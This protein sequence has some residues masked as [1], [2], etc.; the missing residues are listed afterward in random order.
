MPRKG[1]NIYKRKDGRWEGRFVKL[2]ENGRTRFGY[3]Y[4]R[5][6]GEA[7]EKLSTA[8]L[9]WQSSAERLSYVQGTMDSLCRQWLEDSK[10]FL[11]E[12]TVAKYSDYL[13]WY[14][15]PRFSGRDIGHIT[16]NDLSDFCAELMR[17]GGESGQ[18]LSPKTVSEVL[19]VMKQLRNFA[20]SKGCS[21]G[22]TAQTVVIRGKAKPIRVF[23]QPEYERLHA[24][25]LQNPSWEAWGVLLCLYTGIR[26]GELCALK[27]GDF[28]R[29]TAQLRIERTL[30]RINDYS[31][32]EA[33]T[34]IVITPPK[35]ESSI[36]TI[37]LPERIRWLTGFSLP[38]NTVFLTNE[39]DRYLEPRTMQNRFKA[40]LKSCGIRDANFHALRHTF[41]TRC[42]EAGFDV[43]CLSEIL[44][45]ADV[46]ITLDRYVHPTMELKEKEMA[47]LK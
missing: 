22:Y 25:L 36:R 12:S 10:I 5:S 9:E 19:R 16:E 17:D 2:R 21:A 40:M 30:Q 38:A 45:H 28:S 3:V 18:G 43:K 37:P 44:G 39:P 23:S 34:K 32:G 42:I 46:S 35:S 7:K 14:V 6:Y 24:Y 8:R 29:D 11:K 20:A 4:G 41:A 1:D 27:W 26:I 47:K 15:L 33:K 13:R 31:E